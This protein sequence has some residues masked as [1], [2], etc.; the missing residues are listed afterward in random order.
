MTFSTSAQRICVVGT[1]YVGLTTGACL[2]DM[3]NYVACLDIDTR[4]IEQLNRGILPIHEPGLGE[5]VTQ[6]VEAGRLVFTDSYA[7]AIAEAAFI[8]I[9]VGTPDDGNGGA[10]LTQVRGAARSIAEHLDHS[11][12]IINKSTVPIGT[13]DL[14]TR[15]L[16]EHRQ[17]LASFAVVSNPEFLREGSALHDCM[18]P[19]RI[20]LGSDNEDAMA[21]IEGLYHPLDAPIIK[22]DL[23]TAE[24]IKYASN[25]FLATKI[26]FI[27]EVAAICEKLGADVKQ[28]ALGMGFDTRIGAQFLHAGLGFGGS[29]FPKDVKALIRMA[30]DAGQHPQLLD[31]VME[32]NRDR[33]KWVVE[34]LVERLGDLQDKRIALLGIAFKPETDDIREA[35][36]LDLIARLQEAGATVSAYDPVAM[37]NA[38]HVTQNVEFMLDPYEAAS[39][40]DAVVL[41][42]EWNQFNGIDL[43]RLLLGMRGNVLV[44][45]RNLYEPQAALA[46]GFKY[47]GVARGHA[48]EPISTSDEHSESVA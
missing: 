1:G 39:N 17:P 25:A 29:C 4:K 9:A 19:E 32:I 30:R 2:A 22:T 15:I 16:W 11:A 40:A 47:V 20:V 45:G 12:V 28:V 24:M 44:D 33:R 13:G 35:P 5:V 21:R 18:H 31:A 26:S 27:N 37:E 3:G 46:A 7:E 42:T 10:D 8:F 38:R 48:A 23:R 14:V 41:V 36:S 43:T 34:R 6:N